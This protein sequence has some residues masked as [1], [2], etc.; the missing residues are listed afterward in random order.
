[1]SPIETGGYNPGETGE[2]HDAHV[3]SYEKKMTPIVNLLGNL[4]IAEIAHRIDSGDLPEA[5]L[6]SEDVRKAAQDAL[7]AAIGKKKYDKVSQIAN[8]F[9][10]DQKS[11]QEAIID[12]FVKSVE[13]GNFGNACSI[14]EAFTL[15]EDVWKLPAIV[16]ATKRSLTKFL[17]P[18]PGGISSASRLFEFSPA[19]SEQLRASPDVNKAMKNKL[20]EEMSMG[21]HDARL[22]GA[23]R[24]LK[25]LSIS[26]EVLVS[27]EVQSTAEE[28]LARV[29]AHNPN[30][31]DI[32]RVI[33]PFSISQAG[34]DRAAR[35]ALNIAW[36]GWGGGNMK[37]GDAL[38]EKYN[39]SGDEQKELGLEIIR[40]RL[41]LPGEDDIRAIASIMKRAGLSENDLIN[42]EKIL[43][44]MGG[45]VDLS[46]SFRGMNEHDPE[47]R[48][49]AFNKMKKTLPQLFK[50]AKEK[51]GEK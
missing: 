30:S 34:V 15:S 8:L 13:D 50:A 33:Q 43:E 9:N 10:L 40:H 41:S 29:L 47:E 11:I 21:T 27:P 42:D 5:I 14:Q 45:K 23:E 46:G 19:L 51:Y 35:F 37:N 4:Q 32:A 24:V 28:L 25:M 38:I 49:A 48:A 17:A 2:Q 36:S 3:V 7:S 6:I 12:S 20:I 26:K 39:I 44:L 1:M 31:E 18:G 16:E 22:K